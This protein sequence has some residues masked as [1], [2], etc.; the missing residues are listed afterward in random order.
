MQQASEEQRNL[1]KAGAIVKQMGLSQLLAFRIRC[2]V[3][4]YRQVEHLQA[5]LT[6]I[7]N[8]LMC[9]HQRYQLGNVKWQCQKIAWMGLAHML[10]QCTSCTLMST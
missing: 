9:Q 7:I 8:L 5:C 4:W 1:Q 3:R 6:L 2:H 10:R